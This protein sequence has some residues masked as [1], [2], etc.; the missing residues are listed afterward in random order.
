MQF[1]DT[2]LSA[3]KQ[4]AATG[5]VMVVLA[6]LFSCATTPDKPVADSQPVRE[7]VAPALQVDSSVQAQFDQSLALLKSGDYDAAINLLNNVVSVEQR[8]AAPYVNLG[9]AYARKND[10]VHAEEYL[11]KAVDIDLGH[12]VANNELGMLYRKLGRFDDARHAYE[13]ALAPHPEYLPARRN[14]GILCEIYLRDVDCALQ[15][16]ERYLEY[17]PDDKTVTIW[18]ADIKRRAGQ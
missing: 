13:N 15:Q 9:M 2:H 17:V 18:I 8:L 4:I 3:L 10:H 6:P 7:R 11:R 16:Y 5:L 1:I 12:P 14:L